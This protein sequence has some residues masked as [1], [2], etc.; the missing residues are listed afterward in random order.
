LYIHMP[1]SLFQALSTAAVNFFYLHKAPAHFRGPG[2][3]PGGRAPPPPPRTH[4][5]RLRLHCLPVQHMRRKEA[6]PPP[7]TAPR[8]HPPAAPPPA[9]NRS[10]PTGAGAPRTSSSSR[11]GITAGSPMASGERIRRLSRSRATRRPPEGAALG[12]TRD[13]R[14]SMIML[15]WSA[16][17]ATEPS[18][19]PALLETGAG[20]YTAYH[21]SIGVEGA[22]ALHS[23]HP[24]NFL[25]CGP[26]L[27]KSRF[28]GYT[29]NVALPVVPA[30]GTAEDA[31]QEPN[32]A[33]E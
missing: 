17:S 12:S 21:G 14:N 33:T 8:W 28:C 29:D 7:H 9:P 6:Q 16:L 20:L 5:P 32:N 4:A 11:D 23:H 25:C 3:A 13:L 15:A 24:G 1:N 26:G 22:A 2:P 27:V 18:P 31:T 10:A 19:P 30:L